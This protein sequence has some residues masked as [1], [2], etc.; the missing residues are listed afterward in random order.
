MIC[1]AVVLLFYYCASETSHMLAFTVMH[2][3]ARVVSHKLSLQCA[4]VTCKA[5]SIHCF[6]AL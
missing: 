1:A 2:N 3:V 6:S 5:V 4:S